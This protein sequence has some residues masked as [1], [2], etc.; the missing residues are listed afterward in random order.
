MGS[1][2]CI[3][4]R[5][6]Y[7]ESSGTYTEIVYRIDVPQGFAFRCDARNTGEILWREENGN[8]THTN[9]WPFYNSVTVVED[10]I[11]Y[12]VC[13]W[14]NQPEFYVGNGEPFEILI[15]SSYLVE[16]VNYRLTFN[17]ELRPIVTVE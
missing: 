14:G 2:M 11:V 6:Y 4:D 3:R 10:S 9:S 8:W 15:S 5:D 12:T 13:N 17:Y 7:G 1:E 16:N